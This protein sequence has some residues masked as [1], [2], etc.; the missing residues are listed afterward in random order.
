MFHVDHA[1]FDEILHLISLIGLER[2]ASK[3][4]NSSSSEISMKCRLAVTLHWLAGSSHFDLCFAWGIAIG[5]L[6]NK[7]KDSIQP[8]I[9]AL[10]D[11]FDTGSVKLPLT[12]TEQLDQVATSFYDPSGGLLDG[13]IRAIDGFA[14]GT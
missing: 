2:N 4:C 5:T 14:V 10:D 9:K 3:A 7:E 6:Y 11:V 1:T 12:D 13:C 8:T